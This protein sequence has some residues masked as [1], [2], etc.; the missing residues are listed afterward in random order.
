MGGRTDL[1]NLLEGMVKNL[2]NEYVVTDKTFRVSAP[3]G[4]AEAKTV[5]GHALTEQ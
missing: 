1:D 2:L 4:V 5:F 3:S